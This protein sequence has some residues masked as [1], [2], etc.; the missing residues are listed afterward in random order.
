MNTLDFEMV[1]TINDFYLQIPAPVNEKCD[2]IA[3]RV[4]MNDIPD[5]I[6]PINCMNINGQK[7][8]RYNIGS[9]IV[10]KY[11]NHSMTTDD[12]LTLLKNII[13]PLMICKEWFI[14]Y[15]RLYLDTEYIFVDKKTMSVRYIY[16]FDKDFSCTDDDIKKFITDIVNEINIIGDNSIQLDLY[17]YVLGRSFSLEGIWELISNYEKNHQTSDAPVKAPYSLSKQKEPVMEKKAFDAAIDSKPAVQAS[18]EVRAATEPE[19]KPQEASPFMGTDVDDDIAELMQ[20]LNAKAPKKQPKKKNGLFGNI[21]GKKHEAHETQVAA[22]P[23]TAESNEF[24]AMKSEP[25]SYFKKEERIEEHFNE[26][27]DETVFES[28][29]YSGDSSGSPSV[30]LE[31]VSSTIGNMPE[32]IVLNFSKGYVTLGRKSNDVKNKAD[33][34]MPIEAKRISRCHLRIEK[35]NNEYYA[36]DLGSSNGTKVNDERLMPN[37]AVR[38][39]VDSRIAFAQDLA[40]YRF[41]I[42]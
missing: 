36:I 33:Y 23:L 4:I 19:I 22:E 18:K 12:C 24:A 31:L 28:F 32:R 14:D 2:I 29:D 26:T 40:V 21:F 3:E 17:K 16:V 15:S 20:N 9:N 7:I 39:S 42:R 11:F 8:Y 37:Q 10:Y 35:N 34:E 6:I 5:F 41:V 27:D 13:Q 25:Q 1:N 38:L 30:M